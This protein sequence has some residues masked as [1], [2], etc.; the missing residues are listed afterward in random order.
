MGAKNRHQKYTCLVK[1]IEYARQKVYPGAPVTKNGRKLMALILHIDTAGDTAFVSLAKDGIL[2]AAV[3]NEHRNDH[4]SFLQPAIQN[5]L[6]QQ[7]N[8]GQLD[9]IAVNNGPGSYTGLRVG[10]SSAKGFCY[11]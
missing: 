7:L 2:L 1:A 3:Y 5:M 6:A 9:A 11:A 10:L 8:L 4:A